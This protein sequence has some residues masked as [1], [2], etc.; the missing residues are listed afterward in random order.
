MTYYNLEDFKEGIAFDRIKE[1]AA[2]G[3]LYFRNRKLVV[4]LFGRATFTYVAEITGHTCKLGGLF[5][6]NQKEF[7]TVDFL[8]DCDPPGFVRGITLNFIGS[9]VSYNDL[10]RLPRLIDFNALKWLQK[11][12]E[13]I[14]LGEIPKTTPRLIWKDPSGITADINDKQ[15]EKELLVTSYIKKPMGKDPYYCPQDKVF[16]SVQLLFMGGW[17]C[18]DFQGRTIYPYSSSK[19]NYT[20]GE[21]LQIEGEVQ[22]YDQTVP[23]NKL[24]QNKLIQLDGER[25]GLLPNGFKLAPLLRET[26][27]EKGALVLPKSKI[28]LLG[29][30]RPPL[31]N[32]PKKLHATLRPYQQEGVSWLHFLY[33]NSFNGLLAD[34]MG[35]GK[36]VMTLGLLAHIDLQRVLIVM[37]TTL[38]F[39]WKEE[40]RRFLPHASVDIHH[41]KNR[42]KTA[43]TGI[44]LTSYA[45]L[46]QDIDL[47]SSFS[48]DAL[49]LD[50]AHM[51]KNAESQT[52]EAVQKISA[53]FRLSI[54]GTPVENRLSEL[55]NQMAF[56]MPG[57]IEEE[58]DPQAIK[59]KIAPF[60]LR[61]T[62]EE[63][64]KDLPEK[65]EQTVF[66]ELGEKQQAAYQE[67][68]ASAQQNLD[69][70][71]R[72]EILEIIL[73]LRQLA[74]HP[75]LI[76]SP[77]QESAKLEALLDDL[78]ILQQEKQKVII[79]SQFTT[80]L[81][82]IT[83][84]LSRPYLYLDGQTRNREEII[85]QFQNDEKQDLLLMS[86]KAGGVGLNL[87]R[88]DAV[89]IFDPWWNEAVEAQ[90]IARAHR[91]GRQAPVLAKRYIA[92]GTI[93][94]KI[95][96]LKGR[97]KALIA[98]LIDDVIDDKISEA[99]LKSLI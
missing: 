78:A 29:E 85:H 41:G 93:E 34:D 37:P 72:L 95:L 47:L 92:K 62:K 71:T 14:V 9:D 55:K 75:A 38:I 68:L 30:I 44:V 6:I 27:V 21:T 16:D 89:L 73:R 88:A 28:G 57:L 96:E 97:K 19:M 56:L 45:T 5:R 2:Q 76:G 91:L 23:L 81:H 67:F 48:W 77:T 18:Q 7:E 10:K 74:C 46:R 87:T 66:V 69:D 25:V 79:F 43:K 31:L 53:G 4:D 61:R 13:V 59:L 52:S 64:L 90:A 26:R 94:E 65:I 70:K 35:L 22:F 51:I 82:L 49:I 12:A 83:K 32:T 42:T 98:H 54:T 84:S 8:L 1:L 80:M 60:I 50:E 36:T 40:I 99:D 86:L 33:K 39:N 24:T 63:V 17:E 3:K 58:T 11:E 15:F 20:L